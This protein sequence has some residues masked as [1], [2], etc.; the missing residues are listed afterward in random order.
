MNVTIYMPIDQVPQANQDLSVLGEGWDKTFT[1]K[2]EDRTSR[3]E[4]HAVC[5]FG[6]MNDEYWSLLRGLYKARTNAEVGTKIEARYPGC[7]LYA[8]RNPKETMDE[9]NLRPKETKDH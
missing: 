1:V 7:R 6:Y 5:N 3:A 8:G 2:L 9:N 4:T